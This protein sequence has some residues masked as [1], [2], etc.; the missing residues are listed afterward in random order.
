MGTSINVDASDEQMDS[1]MYADNI[2][3]V[4]NKKR[5]CSTGTQRAFASLSVD[6]K[7]LHMF[8]KLENLEQ[9]NRSIENI[10]QGVSV[11]KQ[12]IE[13]VQ[14]RTDYHEQCLKVLA[15]KSIDIEARSRRNNLIF[16]GLAESANED[17]YEL[18]KD[19]LWNEMCLDIDDYY[20]DRIHRLGSLYRA[21][22]RSP[23]PRRP[24]I[25]AFGMYKYTQTILE[26]AYMLR[27]TKYSVSRDFPQE[28]VKARKNLM[29]LYK[30]QRLIRGNKVSLEYPAK[31]VVNGK[32][33]ADAFPDWY[34]VIKQDRCEIIN[35]V[36]SQTGPTD[37]E[38]GVNINSG[39][40]NLNHCDNTQSCVQNQTEF[41]STPPAPPT[42]QIPPTNLN[43]TSEQSGDQRYQSRPVRT[44]AE[45]TSQT[46]QVIRA[47]TPIV[48]TNQHVQLREPQL[49]SGVI[50]NTP[51]YTSNTQRN[52]GSSGNQSDS[53]GTTN[54]TKHG[55]RS[56]IN[57][58]VTVNATGEQPSYTQL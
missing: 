35:T 48:Q 55:Q 17:C 25:V 46:G 57:S 28:I 24:I 16:H 9:S 54:Q 7:L 44:Y 37:R 42:V 3:T 47:D 31:V 11:T 32:T 36:I 38:Y 27:G 58:E 15:Y 21:K 10:A 6:D 53:M 2:R 30:Q 18:L 50:S 12:Q 19:F 52:T 45:V 26:A 41:A 13:Q 49:Y 56:M 34:S 4:Q 14:M 1:Y 39:T 40:V 22:Q 5:R 8:E 23:D 43:R 51:R 29:P 20:I 33:V